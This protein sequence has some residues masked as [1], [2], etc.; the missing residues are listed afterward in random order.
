MPLVEHIQLN[1]SCYMA[2][3][4]ITE[5]LENLLEC[6][7]LND[8]DKTRLDSFGS[9]SRKK[10]FIATRILLQKLLGGGVAIKNN[11]HG[12][13]LLIDSNYEISIL[14]VRTMLVLWLVWGTIWLLI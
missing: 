1:E 6:V 12:K 7:S 10:E 9:V 2:L 11:E 14:I 5:E 13:P 4:K 8:A 3:W